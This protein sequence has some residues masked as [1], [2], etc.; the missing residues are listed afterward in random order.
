MIEPSFPTPQRSTLNVDIV[1]DNYNYSRFL[2]TAIE[3]ALQQTHP[4]VHVVVVDDGSTDDSRA[5]IARYDGRVTAVLKDNGGQ[6]SAVNVGFAR[7]RGDAV[8]FL[9]A[10]DVLLPDTAARVADVFARHGGTVK[11]QYR[12]AVIDGAGRPTGE[13]VPPQ[14]VLLP[15][16]DVRRAEL[17]QPFDLRWVGMSG[18]AFS[19]RAL[20]AVLPMPEADFVNNADDYLKHLVPLRGRV[21]SLEAIGAYYRVHGDNLYALPQSRLDLDHVRQAV[22]FAAST[23]RCLRRDAVALGL[24]MP[25]GPILSVADL[26]NR[27]VSR[28]LEPAAHPLPNDLVPRLALGGFVAAL[29]RQDVRWPV[30]LMFIAWFVGM[31]VL[32]R[33]GARPLAKAFLAPKSRRVLDP[34]L[35]RLARPIGRSGEA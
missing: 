32:P 6:A 27:L 20:A 2:A 29:R 30:K 34:V 25:P 26:A 11:V 19:Y 13:F 15:N 18:N 5:V 21:I 28:K 14:G 3:S 10:D 22:R 33:P 8:I 1:I 35:R 23:R 24:Q 9:D 17:T 7:A 16:G 12:M 4:R 31:A